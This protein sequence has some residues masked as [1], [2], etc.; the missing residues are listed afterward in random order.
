MTEKQ[1]EYIKALLEQ[2]GDYGFLNCEESAINLLGGDNWESN[3]KNIPH[4]TASKV[5]QML[6]ES[7]HQSE[8]AIAH[9]YE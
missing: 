5:I 1:K 2:E 3:Y 6:N 9:G 7:Q 4:A 8:W